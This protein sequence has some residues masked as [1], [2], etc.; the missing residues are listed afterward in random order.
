MMPTPTEIILTSPGDWEAWIAQIRM[1]ADQD[2]WPHVDPETEFLPDDAVDLLTRP[3]EPT[4]Q[5]LNP[6]AT[7]YFQ[8]A[9][10]QR[11]A[12]RE[13]K[14]FYEKDLEKF[15]KQQK[16]DRELRAFIHK[17]TSPEKRLL[18]DPGLDTDDWL[19]I[20]KQNTRLSE[21]HV[22]QKIHKEYQEAHKGFK[23][24]RIDQWL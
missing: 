8:L 4:F 10:P 15:Q 3:I 9:P 1:N 5:E 17:T 14:G 11:K 16:N 19:K 22:K 2:L 12:Y 21:A 7:S 20:L 23:A 24:S 13:A 6:Q 18:L